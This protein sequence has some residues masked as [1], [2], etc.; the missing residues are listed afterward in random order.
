MKKQ[1]IKKKKNYGYNIYTW[2][3]V[4]K[5]GKEKGANIQFTS[6]GP[7]SIST[8]NYTSGT[9]GNPK[10]A[11]VCHNSIILNT[12][13]IEMLG[14]FLKDSDIYISFLPLAHIMETLIIAV[15]VSRGIRIGFYNGN[16]KTLIEDAQ[17]LRPTCM[18]GVPRIFQRVYD[19]IKDKIKKLSPL[20]KKNI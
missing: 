12:D 15:L 5:E 1:K 11:K 9:T 7:D 20:K 3:E 2:E 6:P 13:V 10:G 19:A 18:C 4:A 14:L 16:A 17:I 8:I